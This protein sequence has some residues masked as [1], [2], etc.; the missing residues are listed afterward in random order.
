MT[1]WDIPLLY[2]VVLWKHENN[3]VVFVVSAVKLQYV[4]CW[5]INDHILLFEYGMKEKKM[6]MTSSEYKGILTIIIRVMTGFILYCINF[7]RNNNFTNHD[8][9]L[10]NNPN[11]MTFLLFNLLHLFTVI[12]PHY[13]IL[14]IWDYPFY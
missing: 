5:T 1:R 6:R 13:V 3:D 4:L 10:W 7:T 2:N 14:E 12:Q 8:V 11:D 9:V